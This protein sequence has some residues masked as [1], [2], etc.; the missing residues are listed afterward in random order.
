LER[1][2]NYY[3]LE[4]EQLDEDTSNNT[5]GGETLNYTGKEILAKLKQKKGLS[6]FTTDKLSY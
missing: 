6:L 3:L 4:V 2:S 5:G 1:K